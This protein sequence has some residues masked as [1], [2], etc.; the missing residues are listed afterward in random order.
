MCLCVC[1]CVCV[2]A[3]DIPSRVRPVALCFFTSCHTQQSDTAAVNICL[4]VCVCA[5]ACVCLCVCV[6][7]CARAKDIPSHV[8]P[9]A[10]C[11]FTSCHTQQSDTAAVNICLTVCACACLCVCVCVCA[12]K[13]HSVPRA[14]RCPLLLYFLSYTSK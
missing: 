13:R 2:C 5:C 1:V 11:F 7:V 4:T 6:C 3:K 10:L 9:V 12:C 8:R 14:A